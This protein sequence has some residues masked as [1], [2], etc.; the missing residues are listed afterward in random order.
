MWGLAPYETPT[1]AGSMSV[2]T[3]S[4]PHPQGTMAHDYWELE[5]ASHELAHNLSKTLFGR[6]VIK[7][8]V[9][10]SRLV[11]WTPRWPRRSS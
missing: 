8:S 9:T 3:P 1:E 11:N 7:G 6:L 10:L 5:N 2:H 4:N